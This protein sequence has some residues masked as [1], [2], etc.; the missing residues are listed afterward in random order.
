SVV[1][2]VVHDVIA[3]ADAQEALSG[4]RD[5]LRRIFE[6]R[7]EDLPQTVDH[8]IGTTRGYLHTLRDV[9]PAANERR[10]FWRRSLIE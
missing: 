4:D 7:M 1:S 9:A 6:M 10:W 2:G 8:F 5:E 3:W